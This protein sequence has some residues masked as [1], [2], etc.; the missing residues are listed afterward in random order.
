MHSILPNGRL[1]STPVIFQHLVLGSGR[2]LPNKFDPYPYVLQFNDNKICARVA[3]LNLQQQYNTCSTSC[4]IPPYP[5]NAETYYHSPEIPTRIEVR[6]IEYLTSKNHSKKNPSPKK[7]FKKHLS[8]Q[9]NLLSRA[10]TTRDRS[11]LTKTTQNSKR[12]YLVNCASKSC[13][14]VCSPFNDCTY[15]IHSK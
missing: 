11:L 15:I 9:K 4:S 10:K 7:Q 12:R 1:Q 14:I 13:E 6:N 2:P 3:D 5:T 8:R